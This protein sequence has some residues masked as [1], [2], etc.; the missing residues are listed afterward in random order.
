MAQTRQ[1]TRRWS[2]VV[3][4]GLGCNAA[5]DETLP[6]GTWRIVDQSGAEFFWV[7]DDDERCAV[8]RIAG[9]SPPAPALRPCDLTQPS[10]YHY[11]VGRFFTIVGACNDG[12]ILGWRRFV[13]CEG[14]QD[15]PPLLT[16]G[17]LYECRAGFCQNVDV[18]RFPAGVPNKL[19][20]E[21]ICFGDHERYEEG[22]EDEY[23]DHPDDVAQLID[24]ACPHGYGD[25]PCVTLPAGCRDPG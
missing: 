21:N 4:L 6:A 14:D 18:E 1:P 8:H 5:R 25:F 10:A 11:S 9:V 22:F 13:V 2:F 17:E 7:C 3:V 23:G 19:E 16:Q 12:G 24:A 15:C 20:I